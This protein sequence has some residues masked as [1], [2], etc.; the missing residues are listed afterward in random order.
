MKYLLYYNLDSKFVTDQTS[1]GG[2]GTNV[3]S[4]VDGVAWTK[5]QEKTYYRYASNDSENLTSYTITVHY[6]DSLGGILL[7]DE[8]TT[9]EAYVGKSVKFTIPI[10]TV[11]GYTLQ[12]ESTSIMVSGDTEYTLSY[13][14]DDL[15]KPL[16][17]E[18]ES[19]GY[20]TWISRRVNTGQT[21]LFN[22][23]QY[24]INDGAWTNKTP[25]DVGT[26]S[27]INVPENAKIYVKAGDIIRFRGD[28]PAYCSQETTTVYNGFNGSSARFK[29]SGNIMSLINSTNFSS[30]STFE[31]GTINNFANLFRGA[32]GLTDASRLLMP[33]TALTEECYYFMFSSSGIKK[34]PRL[35]APVL[36][37]YC[38][39]IMFQSCNQ[40]T[41]L[42]DYCLPV[43]TLAK[44][45]YSGMF[46]QCTG[47]V[48][49]LKELPA[50]LLADS[51]Y[52]RMFAHCTRLKYAPNLPATNLA[53]GCYS[54][55]FAFCYS[56]K[57]IP[58]LK[59]TE[60]VNYCY[61]NMFERCS[62]LTEASLPAVI[63]TN[64]SAC[65][66]SMFSQCSNLSYIK[67]L[68]TDI[69]NIPNYYP[70]DGW[71]NG[72]CSAGTFVRSYPTLGNWKI[73]SSGIPSGWAIIDAD[74]EN[75][76]KEYLT[77]EIV[78]D[79]QI[80]WS[81][82]PDKITRT[83][84]Y[85]KNDGEWTS[86]TS[87]DE[88]TPIDVVSGDTVRFRGNNASY[89]EWDTVYHDDYY[90][91]SFRDSTCKFNLRGNLLSLA[92]ST[93]FSSRTASFSY[94]FSEF[95]AFCS[96]LIDASK[97][98]IMRGGHSKL[99]YSCNNLVY[100]PI[101]AP[102]DKRYASYESMFAQCTKLVNSPI[103][104][105]NFEDYGNTPN[106][107]FMFSGCTSLT[108]ITCLSSMAPT[109]YD[110]T[111]YWV[112]GVAQNGVF[113]RN[114]SASGWTMSHSG[115]PTDWTIQVATL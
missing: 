75:Y 44:G 26:Y 115:V 14:A 10:K 56:L 20:I 91:C 98:V 59:A 25:L 83:I 21:A 55:M 35:T 74:K 72:V 71:V 108:A 3:V 37:K 70:F 107:A 54:D 65:C 12:N 11:E 88:G 7:S 29:V 4:V 66:K 93:E 15:D 41:D 46:N 86:I 100:P 17:F 62:G 43:T 6:R 84:E 106:Y 39:D 47:L 51:C 85:S 13:V 27:T 22:T 9:V 113:Y 32:S 49:G 38:Y 19:D 5:D 31:T 110:N 101:L 114:S 105:M 89:L 30:L 102:I 81:G 63:T 40:I 36:G 58:E 77:F 42:S 94:G 2:D 112:E 33:V 69:P 92:N 67:C 18:I 76:Y 68:A 1:A 109:K 64:A 24:S 8:V 61:S 97:L 28:N 53:D 103:L 95:F 87:T 78:T 111:S 104:V 16:T 50:L 23:I 82:R 90:T 79:G 96:K 57:K 34:L 48:N 80:K 99:F 60:L 73:G 45:C 52:S